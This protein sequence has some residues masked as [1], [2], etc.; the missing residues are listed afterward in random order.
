MKLF[1][2]ILFLPL[3]LIGAAVNVLQFNV[4]KGTVG[5]VTPATQNAEF[6]SLAVP[7]VGDYELKVLSTNMLELTAITYKPANIVLGEAVPLNITNWTFIGTNGTGTLPAATAFTVFTNGVAIPVS[8]VQYKRR[9]VRAPETVRDFRIGN[10]LYLQL[11]NGIPTNCVVTVS[12]HTGIWT[13]FN[14][15]T[16]RSWTNVSPA[17]HANH[18]GY[19]PGSMKRGTVSHWMGTGDELNSPTNAFHL[20]NVSDQIVF[21]GT[22]VV[23][24]DVGWAYTPTPYQKVYEADFTSF[25]TEGQYRLFVPSVGCSYPF[26]IDD[27]VAGLFARTAALGMYHQRC[28]TNLAYPWTRNTHDSCHTN[29]AWIPTAAPSYVSNFLDA[30]LADEGDLSCVSC[31]LYPYV[32]QTKVNTIGGHHD[33]GDYSKY[34]TSVGKYCH[35]LLF[36]VDSLPG[37]KN[38]DNLGIPE[39]G[40]GIPDVLQEVKW[41]LDYMAKLQDSDGMVYFLLY[42]TNSQYEPQDPSVNKGQV[43]L[44]KNTTATAQFCGALAEA[45]SSPTFKA[46]YPTE[47]AAYLTKALNAWTAL[48][49]A[50]ATH[51]YTNAFQQ[52]TFSGS[53]FGH[54]DD[55]QYAATALYLATTGAVFHTFLLT[56][57]PTPNSIANRQ[58][59]W[60]SM[61]EGYGAAFR[62]YAFATNTGRMAVGDL[63]AS[64]LAS[65]K[66]EINFQANQVVEWSGQNSF[67]T[68]LFPDYK[69]SKNPAW[70]FGL[71]WAFDAAAGHAL[72]GG[73]TNY[74]TLLHN[75]N[76]TMGANPNNVAFMTGV[77][78]ERQHETVN[79]V[80]LYD[81]RDLPPSGIQLGEI[82]S[83]YD[84][85]RFYPSPERENIS[86]PSDSSA[87]NTYAYYD[88][89]EDTFNTTTE[90]VVSQGARIF[91]VYA[92]I[93]ALN[94]QTNQAWNSQTANILL[95][96]NVVVIGSTGTAAFT[97]TG[98]VPMADALVTWE[99]HGENTTL[100][101]NSSRVLQPTTA[102]T[103]WI[104]AEAQL[105]DGRRLFASTNFSAAQLVTNNIEDHQ[106]SNLTNNAAVIAWWKLDTALTAQGQI[107]TAATLGGTAAVDTV[108]FVWTNRP[109]SGGA[110][111]VGYLGDD[112]NAVIANN[113]IAGSDEV[114]IE[115]MLYIRELEADGNG[116][117]DMISLVGPGSMEL[118]MYMNS[119]DT[120]PTVVGGGSTVAN[121]AATAAAI[122]YN[123]WQH[124]KITL[125]AVGYDVSVDGVSIG[126]FPDTGD[127]ASWGTGGDATLSVGD[128]DGWVDEIVVK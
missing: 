97:N 62:L 3:A 10:W 75:I 120:S 127:Y 49:N 126:T 38:I 23:K 101:R 103:H 104:E 29:L 16:T 47:A 66:A 124:W 125:D 35:T 25:D 2:A 90:W 56:N 82:K 92:Y 17:I 74:N 87:N 20:L 80:A 27:A 84:H 107:T 93:A 110:I 40:D 43:L 88:R 28:G 41:E 53:L 6:Y 4:G 8:G 98:A 34:T 70:Y 85:L 57:C 79:Q 52:I 118:K 46:Q 65:C 59:S 50:F 9:L 122:V 78:F 13:G 18:I 32:S 116:H 15:S 99:V 26:W 22:L 114:S 128:F 36:A 102:G 111:R 42:P 105:P 109:Q 83:G 100:Q 31:G 12:N 11:T 60:W 76:Y 51:G 71:D 91:A 45:A 58:W 96:T 68:S 117:A 106:P 5:G 67:G 30:V 113:L 54:I 94:G 33:A 115:C 112:V 61:V 72:A 77:G 95:S 37:V 81:D 119:S 19:I 73:L 108:S 21:T 121:Q 63:N 69:A 55:M 48:T 1:I 14:V 123:K 39:S 24:P 7:A 89:W 86:Y 44:P 64:Y